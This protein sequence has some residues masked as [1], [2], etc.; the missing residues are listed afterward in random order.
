ML[1]CEHAQRP[2]DYFYYLYGLSPKPA[3]KAFVASVKET[4]TPA[5]FYLVCLPVFVVGL[6]ALEEF[7]SEVSLPTPSEPAVYPCITVATQG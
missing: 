2:G 5:G 6:L 1:A 7:M 4:L 3:V